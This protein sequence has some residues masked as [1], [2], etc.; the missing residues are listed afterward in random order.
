MFKVLI[1]E[2]VIVRAL[3]ISKILATWIRIIVIII[4]ITMIII[5]M[6]F[7][8][9]MKKTGVIRIKGRCYRGC[10]E[11]GRQDL[12]PK[13]DAC[14]ELMNSFCMVWNPLSCSL[15]IIVLFSKW[16]FLSFLLRFFSAIVLNLLF[17]K[18]LILTILGC[19]CELEHMPQFHSF[20]T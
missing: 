17:N 12:G 16:Q 18:L 6:T 5:I 4:T 7:G 8:L 14:W 19:W 3:I 13:S 20:Q 1:I 9:R 15:N 11:G 2:I 10:E